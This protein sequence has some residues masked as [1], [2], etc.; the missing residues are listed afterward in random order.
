MPEAAQTT[1]NVRKATA[2]DAAWFI[3]HVRSLVSEPDVQIPLRPD[4]FV[5]TRDQQAA[6]FSGA[7]GRGDLF[8]IAEVRGECV[9]ELNLR[10]GSR[11]AFKHS[12]LL[13]ISVAREWR[14]RRI[15][16]TLLEHAIEWARSE[17]ALRR[18]ELYVYATNLPA[19]RLYEHYGFMIE[20]TRRGA[21]RVVDG[22]VDDILM[23][24][25]LS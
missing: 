14:N 1:P 9:G 13:G 12:T 2:N 7:A 11:T 19:I 21:V 15:G 10:R 8:L 3:E 24:H 17:A 4:E 22:F 16:S 18:I 23:A 25:V 6:L 5:V 20:G